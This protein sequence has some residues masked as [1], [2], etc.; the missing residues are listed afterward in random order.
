MITIFDDNRNFYPYELMNFPEGESFVKLNIKEKDPVNI[1]WKYENDQELFVL[2]LIFDI[3]NHNKA[4][5]DN[6]YIPYFP[7]ARQDRNTS[8]NQPFSLK[9]FVGC[10]KEI[11]N[12]HKISLESSK[13][14]KLYP[15]KIKIHSLDIHSGVLSSLINNNPY[16]AEITNPELFKSLDSCELIKYFDFSHINCIIC[17]DKGAK[18]RSTQ[19]A[20]KL[21][22]PILY[23]EKTRD[24]NTGRLS[25]PTIVNTENL[26]SD[27][28]YLLVDDIGTGFGTH[29]QLANFIKSKINVPIEIFVSHAGFSNGI[30]P[31]LKVFDRIYTTNSLVK[32][33]NKILDWLLVHGFL[34]DSRQN[35]PLQCIF[36]VDV[37]EVFGLKAL[38]PGQSRCSPDIEQNY[39]LLNIAIQKSLIIENN[40]QVFCD[41]KL[42]NEVYSI[43]QDTTDINTLNQIA[44]EVRSLGN[45][46][47]ID[48][49]AERFLIS[50]ALKR[51]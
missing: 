4:K 31:V 45:N 48:D 40:Q 7:H 43:I 11:I 22:L 20:N 34:L 14:L 42:Y 15:A 18:D 37:E 6:L 17:P 26:R 5:V 25:D 44:D 35:N 23:C 9:V 30:E 33:H 19:W 21:N 27:W 49:D 16:S 3:I 1:L 36:V 47:Y 29:I 10:L 28:K 51:K 50:F 8:D 41:G 38:Q 13:R 24:P 46:G 39:K 2:G 12:L 32:G